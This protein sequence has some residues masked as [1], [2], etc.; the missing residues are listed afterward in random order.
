[1]IEYQIE[2]KIKKLA[3]D[4]S[5]PMKEVAQSVG[6]TE[7]GLAYAFKHH[8]FKVRDLIKASEFFEVPI[9]YFFTDASSLNNYNQVEGNSNLTVQGK[10][11]NG[12]NQS[13]AGKKSDA[14]HELAL[15]RQRVVALEKEVQLKDEIIE[16][17]KNK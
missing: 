8:S 11:N 17:L 16:L 6:M 5:M 2:K 4:R 10:K 1:M 12:S 9:S 13:G 15:L 7:N 3:K 14:E